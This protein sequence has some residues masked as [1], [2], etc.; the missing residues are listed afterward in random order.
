MKEYLIPPRYASSSGSEIIPLPSATQH[1][2]ERLLISGTCNCLKYSPWYMM[3][4]TNGSKC[5]EVM[6]IQMIIFFSD[7]AHIRNA[8]SYYSHKNWQDFQLSSK[9]H[10]CNLKTRKQKYSREFPPFPHTT[11]DHSINPSLWG[12]S[13]RY[14]SQVVGWGRT[15]QEPAPQFCWTLIFKRKK[16]SSFYST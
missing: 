5:Q 2:C 11:L 14:T 10:Q 15:W 16:K 4:S 12:I 1:C 13:W 7:F 8:M 6:T 3:I 9:W